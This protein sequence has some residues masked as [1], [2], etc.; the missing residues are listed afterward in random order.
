VRVL[1]F[2]AAALIVA[3]V[4]LIALSVAQGGA[5]VALIVIIPVVSGSSVTFLAGVALFVAGFFALL[6]AFSGGWEEAPPLPSAGTAEPATP[7]RSGAAGG[8][9]L[10]GPVP[11]VFGSW[12][13]VSRRVRGMLALLGAV[14]L[15]VVVL[16][17]VWFLR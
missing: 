16:A 8:F 15:I 11:I 6:F 14:L 4:A 3:G 13:G 12:R 2:T 1:L 17:F 5:S 7:T 10:I 9:V